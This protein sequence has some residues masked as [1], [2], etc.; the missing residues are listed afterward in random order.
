[1]EPTFAADS[2]SAS[3]CFG[4][5]TSLAVVRLLVSCRMKRNVRVAVEQKVAMV[6]PSG[7]V[8]G[9]WLWVCGLE[10]WRLLGM[11]MEM[12]SGRDAGGRMLAGTDWAG[13][14]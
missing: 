12:K 14:T 4:Q 7:V 5:S 8:G 1:M 13:D 3:I 6:P 10:M 2:P 9:S 11:C